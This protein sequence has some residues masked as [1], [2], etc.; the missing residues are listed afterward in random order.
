MPV[1]SLDSVRTFDRA[2]FLAHCSRAAYEE[3]PIDYCT[4]YS[5][6]LNSFRQ[7]EDENRDTVGFT[8][9]SNG[10]VIVSFR[11]TSSLQNLS[12]DMNLSHREAC[13]GRVHA[14]F[15][16][17]AVGIIGLIKNSLTLLVDNGQKVWFTGHS[18]GGAV[19]L[20]AAKRIV[21]EA[22]HSFSKECVPSHIVTF[23]APKVGDT[24]FATRCPLRD[25]IIP[26]VNED[27][28]VPYMPPILGWDYAH[29]KGAYHYRLAKHHWKQINI[30]SS[31]TRAFIKQCRKQWSKLKSVVVNGTA[32]HSVSRYIEY[33]GN[34]L[35]TSP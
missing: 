7:F 26:I 28:L 11:G 25:K 29:V 10:H 16:S 32:T 3:N 20:L 8:A 13:L 23:G 21:T 18:L 33:L 35:A 1:G 14:G 6:Q 31:L 12:T 19:A 22:E 17:A 2:L 9:K 24:G 15:D 27:D 4:R 5:L 34:N 30:H